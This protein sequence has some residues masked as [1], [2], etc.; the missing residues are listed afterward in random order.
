MNRQALVRI[1]LDEG[2]RYLESARLTL[3]NHRMD[4]EALQSLEH[5]LHALKGMTQCL[6]EKEITDLV[7]RAE[8]LVRECAAAHDENPLGTIPKAG[9]RQAVA[10]IEKSVADFEKRCTRHPSSGVEDGEVMPRHVD[11]PQITADAEQIDGL[12]ESANRLRVAFQRLEHRLGTPR[13]PEELDLRRTLTESLRSLDREIRGIRLMPVRSLIPILESALRRWSDQK[14]V[15]VSFEVRGDQIEADRGIL[16][17]MIEP[18]T[19]LLRNAVAHG[20]ETPEIRRSSG[21]PPRGRILLTTYRD[22][23]RIVFEIVDDGRGVDPRRVAR[24]AAG[25]GIISYDTVPLVEMHQALALLSEERFSTRSS[26]DELAGR[27][28]G[29]PSVREQVERLGGTLNLES[30]PGRGF[31]ARLGV[32]TRITMLDLLQFEVA[33]QVYALPMRGIERIRAIDG[34][35]NAA[36]QAKDAIRFSLRTLLSDP[37]V[38]QD[39]D[40][41][42]AHAQEKEGIVLRLGGQELCLL[43]DRVLT[44]SELI[45]RPI[46]QPLES[47]GPWS[48]AALL[49]AGGMALVIDPARL[50]R[51]APAYA[52]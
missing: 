23:E 11:L 41:N 42:A 6:D 8:E 19:Q 38:G 34:A 39:D 32:P 15:Q 37:I 28:V 52:R 29:L 17:R 50:L 7:Y 24:R 5:D 47:S 45:V 1:F 36:S 48:G 20:I 49:P 27:G 31:V 33:R 21:K 43:V 25:L 16:V 10:E 22:P 46:G 12:F 26:D 9:L 2:R 3:E 51:T 35:P 14:E 18:L 44:R 4:G 30:S 13:S 40:P